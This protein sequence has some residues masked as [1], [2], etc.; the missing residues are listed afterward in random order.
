MANENGNAEELEMTFMPNTIEHLGARL[1][2]TIPPVISELIANSLDADAKKISIHL[3]DA[4]EKII[5]VK[6]NGHGMSF[7]DINTKFLRIGRNRRADQTE[8]GQK[9]PGG[10]LVIGKKGLGKL[11]FFG[12]AKV[13][14]VS[15]VRNQ[16]RNTFALDWEI[17]IADDGDQGLKNYKPTVY[18][19]DLTVDEPDGTTITL[20]NIQRSSEFDAEALANS[21]ARFFIFEDGIDITVQRNDEQ[22][23]LL[24]NERRYATLNRE[25][26][27]SIPEDVAIETDFLHKDRVTGK[28]YTTE[29]PISPN[30]GLRGITLFSRQKLVNMPEYFSDSTSSHVYSYLSGWLEVDFVDDLDEDVIETN[31]QSLNWD[32]PEIEGL[33]DYLRSLVRAIER[34]W[35]AKRKEAQDEKLSTRTTI[36]VPA[37]RESLPKEIEQTFDTVLDTL[38]KDSELPEKDDAAIRSIEQFYKLV[39]PYTYYQYRHLPPQLSEVV[40]DYY[41]NEDYYTAVFEGAKKYVSLVKEK[42]SSPLTDRDLLSNVFRVGNGDTKPKLSVIEGYARP[43][44]TDFESDTLKNITE[45]HGLLAVAMWQAFRCP[46]AHEVSRDLKESELFTEKDCLDALSLLSHLFR[47]LES[48]TVVVASQM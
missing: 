15:T 3:N 21:L 34:E 31:R 26:T 39:P 19:K 44:G 37:W 35:R 33:R 45:G 32:H 38:R 17:I 23:I 10:R 48:S 36:D 42:S 28:I 40:F 4:S 5:T 18:E 12:I 1:Y 6:D 13:I 14:E 47:R 25:F 27:W 29:T 24:T 20:R 16:L 11:S 41:R 8:D 30:T 9:S 46:V 7:D 2:S 22:P 43:N